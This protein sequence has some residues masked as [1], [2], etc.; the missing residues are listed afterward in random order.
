MRGPSNHEIF[1]RYSH[2][3]LDSC[4]VFFV[5][6]VY[7]VFRLGVSAKR[8]GLRL[9]MSPSSSRSSTIHGEE[10]NTSESQVEPGDKQQKLGV[11]GQDLN[12]HEGEKQPR[13]D[14]KVE[15]TE[16]DLEEKLGYAYPGWKKWLILVT[17]L[18]IQISMNSNAGMYGSAVDGIVEKYGVT[19]TKARLGQSM[20]LIAYAFGCELWA[21]W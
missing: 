9:T 21:P 2:P 7:L 11:S 8:L 14:G 12:A 10:T 4:R 5:L 20:F 6:L 19:E 15:L 17:I 16:D 13:A 3:N 18:C 1:L